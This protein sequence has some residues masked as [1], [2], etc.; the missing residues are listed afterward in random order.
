M[1]AKP[2]YHVDLLRAGLEEGRLRAGA[3]DDAVVAGRLQRRLDDALEAVDLLHRRGDDVDV[4]T[5]DERAGVYGG[6]LG[7]VCVHGVDT[8]FVS[9]KS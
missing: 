4:E 5:R 6:K 7:V 9:I 1:R 3:G 8:P 2:E